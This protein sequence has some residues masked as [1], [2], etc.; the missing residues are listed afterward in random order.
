MITIYNSEHYFPIISMKKFFGLL[1]AAIVVVGGIWYVTTQNS[2]KQLTVLSWDYYIGP[3]TIAD[4]EQ[5]TGAKVTY[6][7][8]KSNEEALARI[9]AN[10]GVYD[11]AVISDYMV[12]IMNG[13]NGLETI[14][15]A[16]VP[17]IANIGASFKGSYFDPTMSVSV[18]YAYGTAG[19]AVN[20]K[21]YS[22][23]T[24]S[25]QELTKPAYKGKVAVM[26]DM[27][28]VLGSVLM[29]LGLDP[30]TTNKED[31][32]KAVALFKQ[33][34]PNISKFSSDSP[35]ELMVSEGAW[36]SYGYSGDSLQMQADNPA[37][38]YLLP[39]YGGLKFLDN[40]VIPAGAP[41]KDVAHEWINFI[42]RPDVSAAITDEVQ[43]GNPNTAAYNLIDEA[44][45]TNAAVFPSADVLSKLQYVEDVGDSIDLYNTAWESVKQ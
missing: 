34:V 41:H 24:I 17:N 37:I 19:F 42:L 9:K 33:V 29:E 1:I 30:N 20:T 2:A 11:V 43:Y 4:F 16:A 40:M 36:I 7:L 38:R 21:Y 22:G 10:P 35:V 23:S 26:D 28:Y 32:D 25:W 6:E 45:R 18:P 44:T 12:A 14:D 27:R 13:E 15:A 8:I 3:D 31:I 39:P 5:E